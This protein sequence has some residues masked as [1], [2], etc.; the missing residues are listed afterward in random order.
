ML[1][2]WKSDFI[3][4]LVPSNANVSKLI[5]GSSE[6]IAIRVTRYPILKKLCTYY[7]RPIISTSA[8][9]SG[10]QATRTSKSVLEFFGTKVAILDG[11]VGNFS[12]PSKIFN[13]ITG[14]YI[15][16]G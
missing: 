5:T 14:E 2:A 12:Y 4:F 8:N 7:G 9:I 1:L 15:R 3:T 11:S 6:Y 16:Y 13:I 10:M